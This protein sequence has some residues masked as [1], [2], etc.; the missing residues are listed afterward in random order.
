MNPSLVGR[1]CLSPSRL[2]EQWCFA[3]Y[4]HNS[5]AT[6]GC[7]LRRRL[8]FLDFRASFHFLFWL[9]TASSVRSRWQLIFRCNPF[10]SRD[11][12]AGFPLLRSY[13]SLISWPFRKEGRS[14]DVKHE[15]K[16]NDLSAQRHR[17]RFVA[18]GNDIALGSVR[19]QTIEPRQFGV[20][21]GL[22][23]QNAAHADL[24]T[25]P[26]RRDSTEVFGHPAFRMPDVP[27]RLLK[28]RLEPKEC[29]LR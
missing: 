28:A 16:P 18:N 15:A 14:I 7:A 22:F 1:C 3:F 20:N 24:T 5:P 11:S 17:D 2:W 21:G 26:G 29:G 13:G 8:V 19:P 23:R 27:E 6:R 9:P 25:R 4:Y 10:Y 12:A